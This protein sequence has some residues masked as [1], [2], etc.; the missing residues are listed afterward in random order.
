MKNDDFVVLN[1]IAQTVF[2]KKGSNIL[3][4][5]LRPCSLL[6]EYVVIAEGAVDRHV[7]AIADSV[8]KALDE[9]GLKPAFTEGMQRGDWIVLDYT[10]FAVHLFIPDVREKYQLERLWQ[11]SEIVDVIIDV[12][13]EKFA[14]I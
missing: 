13:R 3:A 8:R 9:I 14:A 7:I 11:K 12:S 2:D 4:L 6:A 1:V 10:Q 5:D